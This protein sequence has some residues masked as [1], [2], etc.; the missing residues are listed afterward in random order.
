M[1]LRKTLPLI[2]GIIL[3]VAGCGG[4]G[5][6]EVKLSDEEMAQRERSQQFKKN[7]GATKGLDSIAEKIKAKQ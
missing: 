1:K 2:A 5:G 7:L 3:T 4:G 6:T